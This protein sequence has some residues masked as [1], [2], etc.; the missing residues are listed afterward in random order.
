MESTPLHMFRCVGVFTLH[1]LVQLDLYLAC[2]EEMYSDVIINLCD[3]ALSFVLYDLYHLRQGLHMIAASWDYH[4]GAVGWI[5][6]F[7]NPV[8]FSW[9][10]SHT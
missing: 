9:Y 1:D 2:A 3:A 10:Q 4:R 7:G 6:L 8:R 5:L